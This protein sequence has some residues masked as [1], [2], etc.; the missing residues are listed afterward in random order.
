MNTAL[1]ELLNKKEYEFITIKEI[2]AKAGVNRS[3]FYLHYNN[4]DD[5]LRECIENQNKQFCKCFKENAKEFIKKINFCEIDELNL[6]TPQ[7]LTPYLNFIKENKMVHQI[8]IKH[9]YIMNSHQKYADLFKYIF[10][11]ILKRFGVEEKKHNF[12]MQYFLN[13]VVA[14]I[15]EW[16]KGGCKEDIC[17]IENIIIECIQPKR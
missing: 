14:I 2:C 1:I 5:L 3:T 11:P 4:I 13:G 16:I 8:A 17:F 10:K 15:N 12:I 9:S 7:Y 6:I